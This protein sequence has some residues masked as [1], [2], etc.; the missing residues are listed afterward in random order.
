[1]S[2]TNK[3][4]QATQEERE[5]IKIAKSFIKQSIALKS[6]PSTKIK[7]TKTNKNSNGDFYIG[8]FVNNMRTGHGVCIFANGDRYEGDWED[9]LT[10]GQGVFTH[11]CGDVFVGEFVAGK[12][13]GKGVYYYHDGHTSEG[14]WAHGK[15][16]GYGKHTYH[17]FNDEGVEGQTES[18]EGLYKKGLRHGFGVYTYSNGDQEQGQWVNGKP[19]GDHEYFKQGDPPSA[20]RTELCSALRRRGVIL[21]NCRKWDNGERTRRGIVQRTM[22]LLKLSLP[23][24]QN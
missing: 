17:F 24:T 10:H 22:D 8:R 19:H 1:M 12:P 9:N 21:K 4:F 20:S 2:V 13:H 23:F 18:Y 5:L 6:A 7:R 14:W 3:F 15:R 16:S 11:P